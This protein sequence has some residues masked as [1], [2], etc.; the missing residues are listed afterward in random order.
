MSSGEL[1][2]QKKGGLTM[3]ENERKRLKA[4]NKKNE[5]FNRELY[6]NA[7]SYAKALFVLSLL[8]LSAFILYLIW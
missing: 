2:S 4:Y 3:T 8:A 5:E 7:R 1:Q 6:D